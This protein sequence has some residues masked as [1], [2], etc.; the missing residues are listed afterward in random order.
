MS[1]SA[2]ESLLL[3]REPQALRDLL[4]Q[5]SARGFHDVPEIVLLSNA[6]FNGAIGAF[7]VS[8]RY[9]CFNSEFFATAM[10][11]SIMAVL[12]EEFGHRLDA[13]LNLMD[14]QIHEGEYLDDGIMGFCALILRTLPYLKVLMWELL[15]LRIG[16]SMVTFRLNRCR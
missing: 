14:A 12:A 11:D 16:A 6:D 5:F 4:S 3:K 13:K 7:A 2:E 1:A 10:Q 8:P 9:D 15:L